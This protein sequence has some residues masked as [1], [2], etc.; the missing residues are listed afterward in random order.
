MYR[1]WSCTQL[2]GR[3]HDGVNEIA[4]PFLQRFI[5]ELAVF[6]E[7]LFDVS[8]GQLREQAKHEAN[9]AQCAW[10]RVFALVTPPSVDINP[11]TLPPTCLSYIQSK[12][13]FITP[14]IVP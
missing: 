11:N 9:E 1:S 6:V 3:V 8:H 7:G 2:S 4:Q 13:F 5:D 14:D 10:L 12:V